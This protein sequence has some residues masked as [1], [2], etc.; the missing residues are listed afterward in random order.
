LLS[1]RGAEGSSKVKPL[2][3]GA[4]RDRNDYSLALVSN[5]CGARSRRGERVCDSGTMLSLADG[6]AHGCTILSL[7]MV[8][9]PPAPL[10]DFSAIAGSI[11]A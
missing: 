2:Y 4:R 5:S 10:R 3:G 11:A 9:R 6:T 7:T 8:V 1:T